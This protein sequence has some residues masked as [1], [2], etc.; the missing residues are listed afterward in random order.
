MSFSYFNLPGT[1]MLEEQAVNARPVFLFGSAVAVSGSTTLAGAVTLQISG[2]LAEDRLA[3]VSDLSQAPTDISALNGTLFWD[4]VPVGSVTGGIGTAL[5]ITINANLNTFLYPRFLEQILESLTYANLSDRPT[6]SRVLSLSVIGGHPVPSFL[7]VT[8]NVTPQNDAPAITSGNGV[9]LRE[10]DLL[11]YTA[12]ATD[13]DR[14]SITWSLGGADAALFTI[15]ARDGK[16][17]LRD[18]LDFERPR[19]ANGD[20]VY[21]LLLRADDGTVVTTQ[22]LAI[23][24]TDVR[25]F[26]LRP[27]ASL[28]AFAENAVNAAPEVLLPGFTLSVGGV[29][30]ARLTVAGLLAE[31]RVSLLDQGPGAGQIGFDGT[32]IRFGGTVIGTAVGGAGETFAIAFNGAASVAAANAVL[33][34]LT[35]RTVSDTPTATRTLVLDLEGAS[36]PTIR[37]PGGDPVSTLQVTV[38]AQDDAPVITSPGGVFAFAENGTGPAYQAA[39]FDPDGTPVVWSLAG[40]DAARFTVDAAGAVRFV[41]APD[42]E[43][44]ADAGADNRYEIAVTATADGVATQRAVTIAV[45]EQREASR[46]ALAGPAPVLGEQQVNAAPQAFAGDVDFAALDSMAFG[47]VAVFGLL[48]EDRVTLRDAGNG[49]G[50][51]GFDGSIVRFGGVAIGS[52]TGGVGEAFTVA[53]NGAATADAVG[54]LIAALGYGNLADAPT[55][56]RALRIEVTDGQ[57]RS[58]NHPPLAS[59]APFAGTAPLPAIDVGTESRPSFADIDGDGREDLV[60][61]TGD[62]E[63]RVWRNT[64]T[65]FTALTGTANPLGGID[66]GTAAAPTF[67]DLTGDG[68]VDLV[69]GSGADGFRLFRNDPG[70]FTELTGAANP[71]AGL[72]FG[73]GTAPTLI[74]LDGDGRLDLVSGRAQSGFRVWQNTTGGF[75]LWDPATNPLAGLAGTSGMAFAFGDLNGDGRTDLVHGESGGTLTAAL[76]EGAGFVPRIGSNQFFPGFDIGN[77]SGPAFG[78]LDGDGLPDLVVGATDGTLTLL[79]NTTPS[80]LAVPLQVIAVNDAPIGPAQRALAAGTEDA[81]FLLRRADLLAGWSDPEGQ[82]LDIATVSLV[83]AP[84]ATLALRADG[85]WDLT[86]PADA[87]GGLVIAYTVTDGAL[88]GSGIATI[89]LL[90]ADD[91]PTGGVTIAFAG[92]TLLALSTLADADGI[93]PLGYQWQVLEA[94]LWQDIAGAATVGLG[95]DAA[96][97][98]KP[99]RVVVSY[100]DGDGTANAIVA[101]F[102]VLAGEG[103]DNW[104]AGGAEGEMQR[105]RRGRDTLMGGEGDDTLVGGAGADVLEGGDGADAFRFRRD[106]ADLV[107]DFVSGIDRIE[108]VGALFGG[109][110]PGALPASWLTFGTEAAGP[111]AQFVYDGTTGQ[112][113]FD[114]DGER[115]GMPIVLA[116]LSGAP[117]LALSDILVV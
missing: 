101:D 24:V 114:R 25:G 9:L 30:N 55:A 110:A 49:P 41:A 5:T 73:V 94:G 96:I 69:A 112:L 43:A 40:A 17:L 76:R 103:G 117:A 36:S 21:D 23:T 90:A 92:N 20:N 111:Q 16:L 12:T 3:V 82:A 32:T 97:I 70:G 39:G 42:F 106:A 93:G 15:D 8:L 7:T 52:A 71:L 100:T 58:V 44:P 19:D 65:G 50:Q 115:D 81:P 68:R 61:G 77:R 4:Q 28:P 1:V 80:G 29:A 38:T 53:L 72:T 107:L 79:R 59:F 14:D 11:N 31:D 75:V 67:G 78:D 18:P 2:L 37:L 99:V 56:F 102:P 47:R 74:D 33:Q 22:A 113:L 108:V 46:L 62:G 6:E 85:D 84:G 88:S 63:F 116:T 105:G 98:G 109:L 87:T 45:T 57:G 54:A 86:P 89:D 51:I 35:Y 26:P 48:P 66:V 60:V 27:T 95:I 34:A 13:P 91:A 83:A 64:G 10:G 104:L